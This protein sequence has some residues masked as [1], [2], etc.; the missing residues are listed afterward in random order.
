MASLGQRSVHKTG[1]QKAI[2]G[3]SRSFPLDVGCLRFQRD[4]GVGEV[5]KTAVYHSLVLT[6]NMKGRG[7]TLEIT[8]VETVFKTIILDEI[9]WGESAATDE[10]WVPQRGAN[11]EVGWRTLGKRGKQEGRCHRAQKKG[12][13]QGGGSE[14]YVELLLRN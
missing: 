10:G 8:F 13:F 11:R 3:Q 7:Q 1:E 9:A 2:R 12:T 5:Q 6:D 14:H 4:I